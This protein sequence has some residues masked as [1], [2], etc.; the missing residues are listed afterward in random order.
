M[1]AVMD[2]GGEGF[3][4]Y[5]S[6]NAS[7]VLYPNNTSSDFRTRLSKPLRLRGKWEI[8]LKSIAY[9]SNLV[10]EKEI[11]RIDCSI[12][13]GESV[14]IN[15]MY[16]YEF[17]TQQNKWR[18]LT[19]AR[20]ARDSASEGD[21]ERD[22]KKYL[23]VMR[24]LNKMQSLII[25]K[26]KSS[27]NALYEFYT[28]IK[29]NHIFAAYKSYDPTFALRISERL[30]RLLGFFPVRQFE[31]S[32][33][34]IARQ[35]LTIFPSK[36]KMSTDHTK[37]DGKNKIV[38][39]TPDE[40]K[41][42]NDI[43]PVPNN[44]ALE[45]LAEYKTVVPSFPPVIT[46]H[47]SGRETASNSRKKISSELQGR[48]ANPPTSSLASAKPPALTSDS[49]TTPARMKPAAE[50][51]L[52]KAAAKYMK[53]WTAL[54]SEDY[55][56]SYF[57]SNIQRLRLTAHIKKDKE[58]LAPKYAE[59]FCRIWTQ[60]VTKQCTK[61]T[62][63]IKD[64]KIIIRNDAKDLVVKL[65]RNLMIALTG[66]ENPNWMWLYR[67]ECPCIIF[68]HG[69]F[70]EFDIAKF[71]KPESQKLST[72]FV[73][74]YSD[75][76]DKTNRFQTT[77]V[78]VS[79]R[80]WHSENIVTAT[81]YINEE[82]K[83]IILGIIPMEYS[84]IDHAFNLEM[85]TPTRAKLTHGKSL[86]PKF[87]ANLAELFG[88]PATY[89]LKPVTDANRDVDKLENHRRNLHV[90]SNVILPSS[91]G[92]QQRHILRGFL[93]SGGGAAIIEKEFHPIMYHPLKNSVI[94]DL[95]IQIVSDKFSPIKVR[96]S[97]TIIILHF[98]TAQ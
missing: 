7:T 59:N 74:I 48:P 62:A 42:E 93:H 49:Q 47:G 96:D 61:I 66:E 16:G 1:T 27:T 28:I 51:K 73:E 67:M 40:T 39:S 8:G 22:P 17:K 24:S 95:R 60:E 32:A 29:D 92:A 3:P 85:V 57:S 87:S 69:S 33:S 88:F 41:K 54:K 34:C 11:G 18:G 83:K 6:S 50:V 36:R 13:T 2:N 12:S 19:G 26:Q 89:L 58:T 55:H 56:I 86:T 81:K 35:K 21:F 76:L 45:R 14:N 46:T 84:N 90:L 31:G 30:S 68:S 77:E 79:V 94:D 63:K 91:Y 71:S 78:S 37:H 43:S 5:L 44:P 98:R 9:S 82:V 65:S 20:P 4:F 97:D 70:A 80:P 52:A 25:K 38:I 72:W 53:D 64:G 10:D 23:N 75:D 15:E